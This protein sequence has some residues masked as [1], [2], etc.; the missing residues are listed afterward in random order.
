MALDIGNDGDWLD[1]LEEGLVDDEHEPKLT[2]QGDSDV[3]KMMDEEYGKDVEER[4]GSDIARM[5]DEEYIPTMDDLVPKGTTG[6]SSSDKDKPSM[7]DLV[8]KI[9]P[10]ELPEGFTMEDLL[11]L[12]GRQ[13]EIDR[14]RNVSQGM[15]L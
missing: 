13:E 12:S 1:E 14:S 6:S 4:D 7:D 9:E 10:S 2:N 5:M 15:H 11:A 8:Q 3:A